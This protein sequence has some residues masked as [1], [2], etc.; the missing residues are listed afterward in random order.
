MTKVEC[1]KMG[2]RYLHAYSVMDVAKPFS[3]DEKS[4]VGLIKL[5]NP[6]GR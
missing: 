2:L 1:E 6:W 3:C 4:M 5:R